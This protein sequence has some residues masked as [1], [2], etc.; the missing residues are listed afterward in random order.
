MNHQTHFTLPD[1][2]V[3]VS[4]IV[5]R[6]APL[7]QAYW[8][9]AGQGTFE[10]NVHGLMVQLYGGSLVLVELLD[11]GRTFGFV[12]GSKLQSIFSRERSMSWTHVYVE[13]SLRNA[14]LLQY[15]RDK[16]Q[17]EVSQRWELDSVYVVANQRTKALHIRMGAEEEAFIMRYPP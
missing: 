4:A 8:K 5:D 7:M 10:L 11:A 17:P 1:N 12:L 2:P 14:G 15:I 3:Q 16:V 9:E 6:L 13:E